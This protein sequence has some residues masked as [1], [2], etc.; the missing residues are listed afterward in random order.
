[1]SAEAA[2]AAAAE[3]AEDKEWEAEA[4]GG[5]N[6]EGQSAE[7]ILNQDE[8]DSLLGFGLG[9]DDGGSRTGVR[10]IINSALISYERLPMLEIVFDRLVRLMTTSLRN[11]TSDNVEVSLDQI[12]SIRFGDYLNSIPLPA[13][14]AVF[15][16]EQLDN[17]G[18]VTVDSSLIYSVV[19]VLLGGRRGAAATRVEGR[20]YTTIERTLVTR[21]IEV[22]LNDARQAFAPLTEVDFTLDRIETNPR[23]AAIARPPN[24]AIVVKL[25]IDMEDRGGRVE[26][27]LP[28]ATLEPI[29]K[30]LLQQFMG[31]KFGRDNIW[32]GHLASELW[33]TKLEVRAVHD[34]LN[35]PLIKV[36]D[37][38]VGDTLM[39]DTPP[40]SQVML[41]CGLVD[42]SRG[43]VGR[44]GHSLAVRVEHAI[45]PA[46]QHAVMKLGDKP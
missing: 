40:D 19:D 29:R 13:I 32:E 3:T 44:M 38:K 42:L 36:V 12:S 43:R 33:A 2:E 15:R 24:A 1:M 46:S 4:E 34:E 16:A 28:Y 14:I 25:R 8:I 5:E 23:F 27:L 20:P 10:A 37:L 41:K 39:L 9:E 7:R 22:V 31:E 17:F 30:M 6:A 35:Q 18:L 21:M 45:A 26:L 11:F